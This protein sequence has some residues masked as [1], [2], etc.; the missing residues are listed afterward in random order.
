MNAAPCILVI[1]F[2]GRIGDTLFM[3]PAIRAIATHFPIHT[4]HVLAHKKTFSLLQ[5]IPFIDNS[6]VISRRSAFFMGRSYK[7]KYEYGFV[8]TAAGETPCKNFID[9]ASRVCKKV[10]AQSNNK[11]LWV[12]SHP[13]IKGQHVIDYFLQ[14]PKDCGIEND[15]NYLSYA[16]SKKERIWAKAFLQTM[17]P[18][19]RLLIGLQLSSFGTRSYRDWPLESYKNLCGRLL[20]LRSDIHFVVLGTDHDKPKSHYLYETLGPNTHDCTGISMRPTAAIMESLDLYIGPDTG[21]S[22]IMSTLGRPMIIVHHC[23]HPS[24]QLAPTPH[25]KMIIIDMPCNSDCNESRS[26]IEISVDTVFT[27]T[28]NLLNI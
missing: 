10:A 25:E 17:L 27:Q 16:V 6:R 22:W 7:K 1:A 4:I 2:S 8:F 15:G 18:K 9:Y 28:R 11:N 19:K 5:E 21:P 12:S 14:L 3:T 26:M 13:Y 20:A 24:S 23:L